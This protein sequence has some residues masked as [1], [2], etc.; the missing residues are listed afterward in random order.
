MATEG[1]SNSGLVIDTSLIIQAIKYYAVIGMGLGLLGVILLLQFGVGEEG[2]G[3]ISGILS[4]VI[5]AFAVLSG[6]VIAAFIGYAT[7][8]TGIGSLRARAANSSIANG[9]GFAVFGIVVVSIL[10]AGLAVLVN[11]GGGE[12]AAGGGGEGSSG[13]LEIAE[14]ITLIVLMMIPN[15]AVGGGITFFLGGRGGAS[16]Q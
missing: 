15:A 10:F 5:L 14:L 8:G 16:P 6:P 2:G 3:L 12:A 9:I 11:G 13:P 4:I 1:Q 7:S